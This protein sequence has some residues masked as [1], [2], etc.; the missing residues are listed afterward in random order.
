MD[1]NRVFWNGAAGF[2]VSL[3]SLLAS[4]NNSSGALWSA[5]V[6]A[7]VMGT[8]AICTEGKRQSELEGGDARTSITPCFLLF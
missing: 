2:A 1:Y 6:G 3:S 4:G 7:I 8:L 5:M